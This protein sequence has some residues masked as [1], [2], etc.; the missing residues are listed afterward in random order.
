[1]LKPY[2]HLK[3]KKWKSLNHVQL[4]ATQWTTSSVHGILQARILKWVV[5]PSFRGSSQ[6]MYQTHVLKFP[7]LA[8]RIFTTSDS[9]EVL[10]PC[11][12]SLP[13]SALPTVTLFGNKEQK[14]SFLYK[15]NWVK[16]RPLQCNLIQYS[17]HPCEKGKFGHR[18]RHTQR[19]DMQTHSKDAKLMMR[20]RLEW[21]KIAENHQKLGRG[22]KESSPRAVRKSMALT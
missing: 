4:F 15:R 2:F 11:H 5:I 17:W 14:D 7:E 20:Q 3:S 10:L 16:V 18:A 1:M 13:P 22:Q 9:W 12:Q 6:P 8:G 19:K 21:R